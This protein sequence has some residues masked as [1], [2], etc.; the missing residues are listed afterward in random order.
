MKYFIILSIAIISISYISKEQDNNLKLDY[1]AIKNKFRYSDLTH[2]EMDTIDWQQRHNIYQRIDT[3]EFYQ[4]FQ[5]TSLVY[6]Y[7]MI[8]LETFYS[9]QS[10]KRKTIEFTTL[11]QQEGSYCEGIMYQIYD[12]EGKLVNSFKVAGGCADGINFSESQGKFINDSTY[13]LTEKYNIV[14]SDSLEEAKYKFTEIVIKKDGKI[15][16]ELFVP[17]SK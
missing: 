4:I 9:S 2:F 1:S 8:N 11:Y 5:D 17:N 16:S 6:E 13:H 15:T 7:D 14:E 10:S 12:L 3:S